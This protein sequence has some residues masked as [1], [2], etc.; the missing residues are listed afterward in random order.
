MSMKDVTNETPS[1]SLK[2]IIVSKI[3][4]ITIDGV[5][6]AIALAAIASL[7]ILGVLLYLYLTS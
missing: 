3:F 6:R 2:V 4:S 7:T 5:G 1:E